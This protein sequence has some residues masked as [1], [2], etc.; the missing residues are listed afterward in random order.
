VPLFHRISKVVAN[1][2]TALRQQITNT[3]QRRLEK[4][5]KATLDEWAQ[6]TTVKARLL[7]GRRVQLVDKACVGI[8]ETVISNTIFYR[9]EYFCAHHFSIPIF[10]HDPSTRIETSP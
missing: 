10:T 3:E 8:D 9:G 6:D 7:T 2:S 5:V 4:A 1:T